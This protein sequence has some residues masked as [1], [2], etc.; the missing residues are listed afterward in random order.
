[1][2]RSRAEVGNDCTVGRCVKE[3]DSLHPAFALV[4]PQDQLIRHVQLILGGGDM[5]CEYVT[6]I[7][8]R[9]YVYTS[10]EVRVTCLALSVSILSCS[11]SVAR[12]SSSSSRR[13]T[14]FSN[15]TMTVFF[16]TFSLLTALSSSSNL[17]SVLPVL[18]R[19]FSLSV[20]QCH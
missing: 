3:R 19:C 20:I 9:R 15:R 17:S 2:L 18:S 13:R 10:R 14:S 8:P 12:W 1:M 16:S 4:L 11:L 5:I 7:N 6:P